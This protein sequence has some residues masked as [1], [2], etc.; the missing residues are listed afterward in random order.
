VLLQGVSVEKP[1]SVAS[2]EDLLR[3][4]LAL[5]P[6]V[7][8]REICVSPGLM[9]NFVFDARADVELQDEVRFIEV[10]RGHSTLSVLPPRDMVPGERLRLTARLGDKASQQ[11]VTLT[12]VAHSGQATHQVEVFRDQRPLESYQH[13]VAQERAKNQQLREELE[14]LRARLEQVQVQLEQSGGLRGL[15]ANKT[16]SV[17]GVQTQAFKEDLLGVSEGVLSVSHGISYRSDRSIAVQMS[18]VNSG[19]EP[20]T[21]AEASLVDASGKEFKGLKIRQDQPI[22]PRRNGSVIIEVEAMGEEVHGECTLTLRDEGS[23]GIT[24]VGVTFP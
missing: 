5:T 3:I 22:P 2:C 7:P 4:E 14:Q 21:A 9:T 12:L 11:S 16:I 24:L 20:W 19:S 1:S 17:T 15:I 10:T 13:E 18:L 8:A 23:R 6:A